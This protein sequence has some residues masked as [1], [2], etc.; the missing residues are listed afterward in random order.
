MLGVQDLKPSTR[1]EI[2]ID[3]DINVGSHTRRDVNAFFR[4]VFCGRIH[5]HWVRNVGM[6]RYPHEPVHGYSYGLV[7][8]CWFEGNECDECA[9]E[10]H[11]LGI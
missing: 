4:E 1:R 7:H 10:E 11:A 9:K 3:V 2:G 5:H 6:K 8:G